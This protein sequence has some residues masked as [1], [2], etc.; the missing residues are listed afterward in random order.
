MGYK[1]ISTRK[2]HCAQEKSSCSQSSR[3]SGLLCSMTFLS[4]S[5]LRTVSN[6]MKSSAEGIALTKG[7]ALVLIRS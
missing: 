5:F 7:F 3:K 6:F 2:L 4:C 1:G